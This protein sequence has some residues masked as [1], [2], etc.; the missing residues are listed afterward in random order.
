MLK[1]KDEKRDEGLICSSNN[2]R[3][4]AMNK[5]IKIGLSVCVILMM[6]SPLVQ[7]MGN[8]MSA[9][10]ATGMDDGERTP[11]L[12]TGPVARPMKLSIPKVALGH[13]AVYRRF[14]KG[15]LVYRPTKS[16]D[17][18]KI[19]LPIA[20]L[21]NPLDGTFDL[22]KCGNTGR[23]L[24]IATGYRKTMQADNASKVE[25]WL[26]PRFLVEKDISGPAV[27]YASTIVHGKWKRTAPVGILFNWGGWGHPYSLAGTTQAARTITLSSDHFLGRWCKRDV[28]EY[29]F[30]S[31]GC[32]TDGPAY[33]HPVALDQEDDTVD[34]G[35][36]PSDVCTLFK[37][38]LKIR[39]H[40]TFRL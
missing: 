15:V 28:A 6:K 24:S 19:E 13:E 36:A 22:S 35:I 3:V 26:T 34:Y 29:D 21:A 30:L 37:T 5:I 2:Q 16:S 14:L 18:G 33:T 32:D 12:A 39:S 4:K 38:R 7:G 27:H 40:F 23:Y 10:E 20:A 17:V 9:F 1:Y 31:C 8:G 25:I 11:L